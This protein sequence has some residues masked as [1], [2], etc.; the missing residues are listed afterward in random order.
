MRYRNT[1]VKQGYDLNGLSPEQ[2]KQISEID[3]LDKT[4]GYIAMSITAESLA[5]DHAELEQI[6]QTLKSKKSELESGLKSTRQNETPES[7]EESSSMGAGIVV[8]LFVAI[9]TGI[10]LLAGSRINKD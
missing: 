3:R 9:F 7:T 8:G 10:A 6:D 1:L 5:E 2:A 4:R